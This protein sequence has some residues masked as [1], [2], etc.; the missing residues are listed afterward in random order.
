MR[1]H[2]LTKGERIALRD[3]SKNKDIIIQKADKGG[4]IVIQN[5]KDYIAQ[6]AKDL[7]DTN[8][9]KKTGKNLTEEFRCKINSMITT[10]EEK[11]EITGGTA[12]LLLNNEECRT[13]Q[14][15]FLPK[16]HKGKI[17]PPGRPIVSGNNCPSEKISIFVD[18]FLQPLV[19]MSKSYIKDTKDFVDIIAKLAPLDRGDIIG[20][21]DVT[22]LYT[23]IPN[24]EGIETVRKLLTLHRKNKKFPSNDSLTA[25]LEMVLKKTTSSLMVRTSYK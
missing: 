23:N 11:K 21:M 16:I 7:Q 22:A 18:C 13:P 4:A 8:F 17:P 2:N 10:L 14:I 12:K 6:C 19:K 9:Y 24:N 20:S 25:L 15:Y 1:K 5:T 3:L